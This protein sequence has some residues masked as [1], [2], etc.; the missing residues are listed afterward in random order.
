M[1]YIDYPSLEALPPDLQEM[2]RVKGS[3]VLQMLMHSPGIAPDLVAFSEA[4]KQKN[5]LPADLMELAILRVGYACDAIYETDRHERYGR[6]A[7]LSKAAIEAAR[8]NKGLVSIRPIEREVI[9]LVDDILK[10]DG[11]SSERRKHA[12]RVFKTGQVS[13][14]VLTVGLYKCV[15]YFLRSFGVDIETSFEPPSM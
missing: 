2:L 6:L 1:V 8:S 7:G 12:L 11:L 10:N 4:V 13:D 9:F 5:S 3:N 15:C 14:L